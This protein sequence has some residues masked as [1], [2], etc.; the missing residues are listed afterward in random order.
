[1]K[2][3]VILFTSALSL[4]LVG[5]GSDPAT[6]P[7]VKPTIILKQR[8]ASDYAQIEVDLALSQGTT[9]KNLVNKFIA[10]QNADGSWID[11]N[12]DLIPTDENPIREHLARLKTIAAGRSLELN[13]NAAEATIRALDYWY[14]ADRINSNWWWNEIGKQLALGPVAMMLDDE[15]PSSLAEKIANDMPTRPYK[16]SANRTEIS[17]GV[18]WGGLIKNLE[19]QVK[20]GLDGIEETIVVTDKEGIQADYSFQQHGP[21]LYTAGYGRDYFSTVS[22]WAYQV[23]DL[24]W[25]FSSK[26]VDILSHY[27]L[28]GVRWSNSHGTLDYNASGRG[29]SR[30]DTPNF[31]PMLNEINYIAE[32]NPSRKQEADEFKQHVQGGESGLQGFKSFWRSDYAVKMGANHF[33]SIKMNSARTVPTESGNNENLKG[34]WLGFGSTFIMQRGDE[35]RNLFPVWDWRTLPGVTAPHTDNTPAAWGK[36]EQ[37]NTFVGIVSDGKY[38]VATMDMNYFDTKAQKS[39][40]SFDDELVAL[41]TGIE[42]TRNENVSTT[43]NQARLNGPVTVDGVIYDKGSRPLVGANW[44]HHDNVGYV[45]PVNYSGHMSNQIENGRWKTINDGESDNLV[46][47]QVFMLRIDHGRQPTNMSYQYIIVPEKTAEETKQYAQDMPVTVLT[48]TKQIQAVRHNDLN[49]TG[50]IFYKA[51]TQDLG[52]GTLITVDKPSAILIDESN[53]EPQVT[54]S[55]PGV[56]ANVKVTFE[57]NGIIKS[58]NVLTSSEINLLGKSVMVDFSW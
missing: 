50:L 19:S 8:I 9:L 45:F 2:T 32:L 11:I 25:N 49:V 26:S 31:S 22:Y 17:K 20:I 42:S 6:E 35:Y 13:P 54:L 33:I 39:W 15:L 43:V 12:Y 29:I 40:F 53:E 55:T 38:G 23:R 27:L 41:G 58:A 7:E 56:G 5:C 18:I 34:Q 57:R 48:N 10:T 46:E 47:E 52:N 3:K 37:T 44:V 30:P 36:I 14:S 51:G 4:M 16:T 28:D 24:Q 21:Q 1:M